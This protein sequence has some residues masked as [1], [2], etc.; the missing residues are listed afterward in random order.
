MAGLNNLGLGFIFRA[1]DFASPVMRK[2]EGRFKKLSATTAMAGASMTQA[3]GGMAAGL[4]VAAVGAVGLAA[5]FKAANAFGGF[6][7]ELARVGA[8]T[9]ATG[10]DLQLLK[11]RAIKAGIETQ[12]SPDEA[13]QGLTELGLRGFKAMQATKALGGALD[14]AAGAQV[15]VAQ[16]ASTT[17]AALKVF[18][19][20][21]GEATVAADKL[22]KISNITAVQGKDLELMLG[23]VSRGATLA[24]QSLDEMLVSMGLV[25][26]TGVEASVAASSVSSA[27]QFM[28]KNSDKFKDM[29]VAVTNADGTFRDFLDIVLDTDKVLKRDIPNA[30]DRA[31]KG[32]E[33]FGRFG[34][35]SFAA[36]SKQV[37]T[38]I[39]TI[40]GETLRGADAIAHLRREMEDSA[41]TA[42]K[43]REQLL[44]TFEG[45]K[46]LLGG[47][48]QTLAV[49][50]GEAFAGAWKPIIS[51]VIDVVNNI[52]AALQTMPAPLKKV[53]AGVVILGSAVLLLTG[54]VM[55]GVAAVALFKFA[56][57]AFGAQ[58]KATMMFVGAGAAVLLGLVAVFKTVKYAFDENIG[59]FGD[60]VKEVFGKVQLYFGAIQQLMSG[61]GRLS[62]GVL[63]KLLDP[64][65]KG[66]LTM[67]QRFQQARHR[68]TMFFTGLKEGFQ[69]VIKTATPT[70]EAL[71]SAFNSLATAF[72]FGSTA[73]GLMT[74]SSGTFMSAGES[75]GDVIG[76]V[77][78][79][80]VDL[81]TAGI[82]MLVGAVSI[83]KVAW[84]ILKP[85]LMGVGWVFIQIFKIFSGILSLFNIFLPVGDSAS[86]V[87][88]AIGI[89]IA[90]AAAKMLLFNKGMKLWLLLSKGAAVVGAAV[91]GSIAAVGTAASAGAMAILGPVGIAAA[92]IA[93]GVAFGQW[94][95]KDGG[96]TDKLFGFNQQLYKTEEELNK[97]GLTGKRG[98][99][100]VGDLEAVA[101][102]RGM[103]KSKFIDVRSGE[104]A[105]EQGASGR[106]LT[107][108][109][110]AARM[111]EGGGDYLRDLSKLEMEKFGTSG[112]A[113]KKDGKLNDSDRTSDAARD[114][115]AGA[116]ADHAN[117]QRSKK[118]KQV[119]EV[120][121]K[122]GDTDLA[123]EVEDAQRTLAALDYEGG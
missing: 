109:V 120:N 35:S 3:M 96:W 15:S 99:P 26:N 88:N 72:G 97:L 87:W 21:A 113:A 55:M 14:F 84:E 65:N 110:I 85:I 29:G 83:A 7:Q 73:M 75:V 79:V 52:I 123:T 57:V 92:A 30:A 42:A 51:F 76:R 2:V 74:S 25:R 91:S 106:G 11:E 80:A 94:M 107:K 28:A 54:I 27:L 70:F 101:K 59:G 33:L 98:A 9:R 10:A 1:T 19:M 53:I 6:Q 34:V 43:F 32:L 38:G 86:F 117:K 108:E 45:Q 39:Q 46:V 114:A 56:W 20:E 44:D 50:V 119:L 122:I 67:V 118:G 68:V 63:K 8:I 24:G 115:F 71:K 62:G 4:G 100:K 77:M 89:A 41:G 58:V 23:T 40:S 47:S 49:T 66:I 22:L 112:I 37:E 81:L 105:G 102:Q 95:D 82:H 103:T 78:V 104:L 64:A 69:N 31:K 90:G 5:S 121:L 16:G 18:G 13:V 61:D 12:F 93:A 48:M 17:A 111:A 36:V 60:A 116:L